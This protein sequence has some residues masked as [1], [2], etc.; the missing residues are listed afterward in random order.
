MCTLHMGRLN[1]R[2]YGA[3]SGALGDPGAP[4]LYPGSIGVGTACA[5]AEIPD[6]RTAEVVSKAF[7]VAVQR[8]MEEAVLPQPFGAVHRRVCRGDQA[9]RVSGVFGEAGRAGAEVQ[10]ETQL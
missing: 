3:S 7:S 5:P 10:G 8:R 6:M 1:I 4:G 2:G 9:M